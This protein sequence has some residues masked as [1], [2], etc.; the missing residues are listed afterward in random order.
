MES[1]LGDETLKIISTADVRSFTFLHEHILSTI[2]RS[3]L[4]Q[5]KANGDEAMQV[6]YA[7]PTYVY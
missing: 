6:Q 2:A 7:Q 3:Y 5:G 1:E 4:R